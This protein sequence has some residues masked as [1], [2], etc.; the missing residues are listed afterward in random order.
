VQLVQNASAEAPQET[1]DMTD[2]AF[3]SL[4]RQLIP[5]ANVQAATQTAAPRTAPMYRL[6]PKGNPPHGP[7]WALAK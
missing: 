5:G 1:K 7:Q 3:G 4:L 2:T 6:L